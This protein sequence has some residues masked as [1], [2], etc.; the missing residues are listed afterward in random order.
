MAVYLLGF[1]EPD[2]KLRQPRIQLG[3]HDDMCEDVPA[4]WLLK[5]KKTMYFTG[6]ADAHSVRSKMQFMMTPL[7]T[8]DDFN[9]HEPAFKDV[10]EYLLTLEA[11]KYPFPI[12]REKASV[13]EK[14]FGEA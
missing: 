13:G 4:W 5:K 10:Q 12:D 8:I 3:L 1:R 7:T 9:R 2:L 14:I 6:G 11:P